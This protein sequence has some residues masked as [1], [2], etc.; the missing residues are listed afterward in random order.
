MRNCPHRPQN[1][2][3]DTFKQ[4]QRKAAER[5]KIQRRTRTDGDEHKDAKLSASG[6]KGKQQKGD[7]QHQTEQPVKQRR[8]TAMAAA[9]H[10]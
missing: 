8:Q 5:E 4:P 1:Q 2:L 9:Q 6:V 10:T 3:T 7:E